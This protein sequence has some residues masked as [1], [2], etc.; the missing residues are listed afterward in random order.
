MKKINSILMAVVLV[1]S[2]CVTF[3]A[4]AAGHTVKCS[5]GFVTGSDYGD[6][7]YYEYDAFADYVS[8]NE[9][10]IHFDT[11]KYD[12]EFFESKDL[13]V[14][15]LTESNES[16]GSKFMATDVQ[17]DEDGSFCVYAQ[18]T[19]IGVTDDCVT[20]MLII[21]VDKEYG[22]KYDGFIYSENNP[23]VI[24][25]AED[26]I[27]LRDDVNRG[28]T[29]EYRK[30]MLAADL[31]LT[32]NCAESG[33]TPIGTEDHPF[34]GLFEGNGHTIKG[35]TISSQN[36][37]SGLFGYTEYKS[38]ISDLT[39][40]ASVTASTNTNKSHYAGA[41]VGKNNG[42]VE[43]CISAGE[44]T[45]SGR[46]ASGGIIIGG[47]VG[48]NNGIIRKCENRAAVSTESWL[49]GGICGRNRGTIENCL[50][51]GNVSGEYILGGICAQAIYGKIENCCSIGGVTGKDVVGEIVG[52]DI[53]NCYCLSDK[54]I[55]E[56]GV[57]GVTTDEFA[58][59]SVAYRLGSEWG[60]T[61]GTDPY[62]VLG[63]AKVYLYN[64]T[65]T[66]TSPESLY[67]YEITDLRIKGEGVGLTVEAD[68]VINEK[69]NE[70][71]CFFVA[72][73]DEEGELLSL[74]Y[75]KANF[76]FEGECSFG[77][78]VPV[79]G[80]PVGSVKAFIWSTSA[81]MKP[82]AEEKTLNIAEYVSE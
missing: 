40:E 23:V 43:N 38:S 70:K 6:I 66:N 32:E 57:F 31:D 64:D 63:G 17:Y 47:I 15:P 7:W 78:S 60:Q 46:A 80:Q 67:P 26:L 16:S 72:V 50:N 65:Y 55:S 20:W 19:E 39:V 42:I 9:K 76:T 24:V 56:N 52:D 48:F 10:C 58:S 27:K 8:R 12:R 37:E 1:L 44:I 53:H 73:Y 29:Y 74:D 69:R 71:D 75:V 49:A 34:D 82:L 81:S 30:I 13:W 79:R 68:V 77:F 28:N 11:E 62:P 51:S 18:R 35:I 14:E 22:S 36:T 41:V 25:T 2:G 61:I 3:S 21:E 54:T 4:Q 33:W 45:A 59:G 5:F